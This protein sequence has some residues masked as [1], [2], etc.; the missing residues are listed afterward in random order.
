MPH[1]VIVA[2]HEYIDCQ[3]RWNIPVSAAVA[4]KCEMKMHAFWY[5]WAGKSIAQKILHTELDHSDFMILVGVADSSTYG[6]AGDPSW[7]APQAWQV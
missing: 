7:L 5:R 2:C 1:L 6:G 3:Y 4:R